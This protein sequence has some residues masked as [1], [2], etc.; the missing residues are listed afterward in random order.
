MVG[1]ASL[2]LIVRS[3]ARYSNNMNLTSNV[4]SAN[5]VFLLM[6]SIV[7]VAAGAAILVVVGTWRSRSGAMVIE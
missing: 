1:V 3:V 2:S 7:L 6:F 4:R 5:V